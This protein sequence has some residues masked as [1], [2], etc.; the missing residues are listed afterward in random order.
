MADIETVAGSIAA[1]LNAETQ[2]VSAKKKGFF[3]R[4]FSR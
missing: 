1:V 4:L 3:A 2:D